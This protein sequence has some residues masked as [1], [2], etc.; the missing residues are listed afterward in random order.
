MKC[1]V[2]PV[3]LYEANCVV[4]WD[5]PEKA[6]VFDPGADGKRILAH[7]KK[8]GLRAGAVV[9]THAH[10]DHVS[11]L[12]EVLAGCPPVP[13]Y[14]HAKDEP[15]AFSP[16]NQMPPYSATQRP[17]ALDTGKRDGDTITCGGLTAKI[18][19][20][21]GHTPGS[22]CLYFED[23]KL[24]VTGDTLFNGSIGRTDFPGGSMREMEASLQRLKQL[25]DDTRLICGHGP[26]ST[27]G[28]EKR[29]NPYLQ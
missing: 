29:D 17:T 4:V 25:P 28:A 20:T 2:L 11:A 27:L 12:N 13:V 7:L 22:W 14:L 23:D 15:F 19:H 10:F 9:L 21:P 6:W 3:G 8:E 16:L 1:E 24:L 26:E 5:D 18:I